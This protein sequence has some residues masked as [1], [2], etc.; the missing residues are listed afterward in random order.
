MPL[1]SPFP[2]TTLAPLILFGGPSFLNSFGSEGIKV[3]FAINSLI[4]GTYLYS[5]FMFFVT[6]NLSALSGIV[7]YFVLDITL[8]DKA[9]KTKN[10]NIP[11]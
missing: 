7:C 10:I 8:F 2:G 5:R 1:G 4:L 11:E 6:L 9:L 3:P